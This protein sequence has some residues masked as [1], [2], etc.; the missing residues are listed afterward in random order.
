MKIIEIDD[1]VYE[2]LGKLAKPFVE[3][4][5]NDVLRRLLDLKINIP[6]PIKI[7]L[8]D[9][10]GEFDESKPYDQNKILIEKLRLAS[11]HVHPAFLTFLMDKHYNTHGNFKTPDIISF[12]DSYNLKL[13]SGLFRNPWM[14]S[15]Y[16]GEDNGTI[17][18]TRTIE[19][20][21]QARRFA[22][23]LGRNRKFDC[24]EN[25]SCRY[26]PDSNSDIRNKCDL[27]KG[28]IWKKLNY[29]SPFSYGA[30]YIDVVDKELL[31]GKGIL[32]KPI[33]AVFYPQNEFNSE[34]IRLF[35]HDFNLRD[36]E[37]KLFIVI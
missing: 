28:V 10:K 35:K 15:A 19:H 9:S 21:R 34:T 26:H 25:Y 33:L 24:N 5:P 36:D 7:L 8:D 20:F 13:N 2:K 30:N 17:S 23:W 14:K 37:M 16:K 12:M 32:L 6:M 18:C 31:D 4:S 3:K 11:L 1:E 22:C 29:E 27:R